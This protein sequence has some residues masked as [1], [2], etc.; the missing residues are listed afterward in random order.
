MRVIS[1]LNRLTVVF[2]IFILFIVSACVSDPDI[3]G[4]GEGAPMFGADA[5]SLLALSASIPVDNKYSYQVLRKEI[6]IANLGSGVLEETTTAVMRI[7][8]LAAVDYWSILTVGWQAWR[9]ES[10]RL[11]ARVISPSG[12]ISV[13]DQSKIV[14]SSD[15]NSDLT[16]RTD[17]RQLSA[18]VPKLATGCLLEY[19]VVEKLY[20]AKAET[21]NSGIR[22]LAEMVPIEYLRVSLSYPNDSPLFYHLTGATAIETNVEYGSDSRNV[23]WEFERL[24][25]MDE[26]EDLLPYDQAPASVLSYS[27][28]ETWTQVARAYNTL[29]AE[30]LQPAPVADW[31]R[32]KLGGLDVSGDPLAAVKVLTSALQAQVRYTGINFG[33]NAIIPRMPS[34]SLHNGY[35]DCKD[36]ASLLAAALRSVGIPANLV[37]LNSG[38]NFDVDATVPGL[39]FFNHAIV[40]VP[41]LDL[42]VDP[43]DIFSPP[44]RMHAGNRARLALV[45]ADDTLGLQRIP[46]ALPGE[47][48]YREVKQIQLSSSGPAISV[49]ETTSSGGNTDRFLRGRWSGPYDEGVKYLVDY[50]KERYESERVEA[51][52]GKA[53]DLSR[54][55]FLELTAYDSWIGETDTQ[56]AELSLRAGSLFSI[57]PDALDPDDTKVGSLKRINN[58]YIPNVPRSEL[59]YEVTAPAGHRLVHLPDNYE[60]NLGPASLT[61]EFSSEDPQHLTARFTLDFSERLISPR[62][63]SQ[64]LS[65]VQRFYNSNAPLASFENIGMAYANAGQFREAL[66]EFKALQDTYPEE[67]LH[68][69]QAADVLRKARLVEDAIEEAAKGIAL[70]PDSSSGHRDFAYLLTYN[71]FGEQLGAGTDISRAIDEYRQAWEL[72]NADFISLFNRAF[73]LQYDSEGIFRGKTADLQAALAVYRS[74]L[75]KIEEYQKVEQY[76]NFLF[77]L[78]DYNGILDFLATVEDSGVGGAYYIAALARARGVSSALSRASAILT[79]VTARRKAIA[80]AAFFLLGKRDYQNAAELMLAAS[81]GTADYA[82]NVNFANIIKVLRPAQALSLAEAQS[83]PE[84]LLQ[85]LLYNLLVGDN[86]DTGVFASF[87]QIETAE[88]INQNLEPVLRQLNSSLEQVGFTGA[89][90]ADFMLSILN[91]RQAEIGPLVLLDVSA[92]ALGI[93][94]LYNVLLLKEGSRYLLLDIN[95]SGGLSALIWK[96][97]QDHENETLTAILKTVL[98]PSSVLPGFDTQLVTYFSSLLQPEVLTLESVAVSAAALGGWREWPDQTK[99]LLELCLVALKNELPGK[100][101]TLLAELIIRMSAALPEGTVEINQFELASTVAENEEQYALFARVLNYAG[102]HQYGKDL[103]IQGL[104][105]YPA[106]IVLQR[107]LGTAAGSLGDIR[108]NHERASE[109]IRNGVAEANDYNIAIWAA[110]FLDDVDLAGFNDLGMIN[111]LIERSPAAVHTAVCYLGALGKYEES[112]SVFSKMMQDQTGLESASLWLAHGYLALAFG[113]PERA[114]ASFRKAADGDVSDPL[115]SAALGKLQAERMSREY[116]EGKQ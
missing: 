74:G 111:R 18:P 45:I 52:L 10:P 66:S 46:A 54:P 99:E 70:D 33:E 42:Y 64:Y 9:G 108:E 85:Y 115:S 29:T 60:L 32:E 104:Q 23:T 16:L 91:Y 62:V 93:D 41:G 96:L 68:H 107:E 20:P 27:T 56:R 55:F 31:A 28:L 101:K 30:Y 109:L 35:G 113:F 25:A 112:A 72:N 51:R 3:L 4:R 78:D 79:D 73:L 114:A 36:Q 77:Y 95:D 22:Y 7:N 87:R 13:L 49:V 40:Y 6:R 88:T 50:G 37:L 97:Y 76:C 14:E 83:S 80:S 86:F 38:T 19:T 100:R 98:N 90:V 24:P 65:A 47:D 1:V 103:A 48:W 116:P 15:T 63:Y 8:S 61:A 21:G 43:T 82:S 17:G 44:G 11:S 59:V 75:H 34:D 102:Y 26:I 81:R 2:A 105:L 53:E 5:E 69:F 71:S 92:P 84:S 67:P 12:E 89:S 94:Q 110:L 39:E 58:I 106:N 57:L